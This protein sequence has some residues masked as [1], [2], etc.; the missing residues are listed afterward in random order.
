[1]FTSTKETAG[2]MGDTKPSSTKAPHKT[3]KTE[4]VNQFRLLRQV[5]LIHKCHAIE[6]EGA[7]LKGV[8][9]VLK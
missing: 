9:S 1:M 7:K 5:Y 3:S 4:N 6:R 8:L 2:C